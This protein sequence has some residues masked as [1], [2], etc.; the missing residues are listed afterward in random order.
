[1][2]FPGLIQREKVGEHRGS[3]LQREDDVPS[4][5]VCSEPAGTKPHPQLCQ[6][7]LDRAS[8]A[9]LE[10]SYKNSIENS[11]DIQVPLCLQ[12]ITHSENTFSMFLPPIICSGGQTPA[13]HPNI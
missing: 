5:G 3:R 1:M 9:G 11:I 4:A 8:A 6:T 13:F 2:S 7:D 10:K 12:S